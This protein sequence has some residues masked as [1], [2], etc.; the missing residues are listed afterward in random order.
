MFVK[1]I[2]YDHSKWQAVSAGRKTLALLPIQHMYRAR[3]AANRERINEKDQLG[4]TPLHL[5]MD[6]GKIEAIK[7][8]VNKGADMNA[9]DN[10]KR[11]PLYYIE[12]RPNE[13]LEEFLRE[14]GA[15]I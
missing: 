6:G 12:M 3:S 8:L 5:A 9:K 10:D 4:Q 13:E 11:T 1:Q 15:K 7:F 2:L 14:K